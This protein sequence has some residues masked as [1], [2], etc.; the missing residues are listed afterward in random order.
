MPLR[1]R[2][3]QSWI[4]L[5]AV[6]VTHMKSSLRRRQRQLRSIHQEGVSGYDIA[7]VASPRPLRCLRA[8]IPRGVSTCVRHYAL[9]RRDRVKVHSERDTR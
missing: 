8:V 6:V 3:F 2:T 1:H 5:R 9:A 4:Q 7:I